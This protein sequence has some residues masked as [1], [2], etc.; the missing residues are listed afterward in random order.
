MLRLA[1]VSDGGHLIGL[2]LMRSTENRQ[3]MFDNHSR[4]RDED[5]SLKY[6][7][8]FL[9]LAVAC[10]VSTLTAWDVLGW[11]GLTFLYAAIS[12]FLLAV[13]YGGA[14]PGLLLKSSYGCR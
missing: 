8:I 6:A 3:Q 11:L 2:C 4:S 7:I 9:L 13:A 12:F 5:E 1:S 14:G 10:V